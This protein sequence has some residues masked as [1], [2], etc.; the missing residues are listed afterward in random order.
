M[1]YK[2]QWYKPLV[3][4]FIINNLT[5]P[6]RRQWKYT[7]VNRRFSADIISNKHSLLFGEIK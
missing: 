3:L 1:K 2:P 5:H 7:I 6:A 4:D